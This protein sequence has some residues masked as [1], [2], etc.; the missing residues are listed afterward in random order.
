M[1]TNTQSTQTYILVVTVQACIAG[2]L[3]SGAIYETYK[4]TCA[5]TGSYHLPCAT[6]FPCTRH[7]RVGKCIRDIPDTTT[8]I[9]KDNVGAR[10]QAHRFTI[11]SFA[12][13]NTLTCIKRNPLTQYG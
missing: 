7:I 2:L 9:M 1:T 11:V 5:V 3:A 4:H 10:R 12:L 13:A 8:V 6:Q